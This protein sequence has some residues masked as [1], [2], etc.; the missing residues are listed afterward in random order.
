MVQISD[1]TRGA[2]MMMGSMAAFTFNDAFM[3][4]LSGDLPLFQAVFLRGICVTALLCVLCVGLGQ[5][6]A[7]FSRADW[8]LIA[9]RGV[10][11]IVVAYLFITALF[12]MPIANVSAILQA[13]PLTV[14]LAAAVFLGE[15]LGWRRLTAII[16]GFVGVL[17]IVQPGGAGFNVYALWVLAAV[18]IVTIRDL[19]ARKMSRDVPSV[20]AAL[21]AGAMV[22]VAA[23]IASAFIPWVPIT[24]A[25][26]LKLGAAA[27]FIIGGYVF[28]VAAMRVG[29][30]SAVAPFRYTSLLVALI[31]GVVV[32]GEWPNT[33]A[34]LGATLVVATGLFTLYREGRIRRQ[35]RAAD[36]LK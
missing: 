21:V 23:G 11:E 17:M 22:T 3:K 12:N 26:G 16:I 30:I 4:A 18:F 5:L 13:L 35:A 2:L 1:N 9:I 19:A 28:S 25:A 31:L 36:I 24:A 8:T 33:L 6:R 7:G 14:S 20:M 32:F 10:C 29:D 27:L 34:L 15:A